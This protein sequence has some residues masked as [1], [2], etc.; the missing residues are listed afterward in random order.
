MVSRCPVCGAKLK[1]VE[2]DGVP[3]EQCT[4]CRYVKPLEQPVTGQAEPVTAN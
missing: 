1:D 3:R 4:K 2:V